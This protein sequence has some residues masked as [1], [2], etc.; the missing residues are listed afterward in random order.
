MLAH[1]RLFDR[2]RLLRFAH[3]PDRGARA[4][5][6][7]LAQIVVAHRDALAIEAQHQQAFRRIHL[8]QAPRL[9]RK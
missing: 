3:L 5:H 6:R 1:T 2:T 8:V 4:R 9:Q 7:R